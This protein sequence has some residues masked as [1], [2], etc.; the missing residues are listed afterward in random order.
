MK[1]FII[2][3]A[4]IVLA[5]NTATFATLTDGLVAYWSF[6]ATNAVDN[7]GNG[8]DGTIHGG[9]TP[10]AGMFGNAYKFDGTG[11]IDAAHSSAFG[12]TNNL[13]I[14]AW[15]NYSGTIG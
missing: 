11:W 6:N 13:T 9:V 5:F 12:L 10:I 8:H 14:G 15:F 2:S 3:I 1:G 4:V 7:S